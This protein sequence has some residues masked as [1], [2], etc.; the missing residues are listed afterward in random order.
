MVQRYIVLRSFCFIPDH[1]KP[2]LAIF[3][4]PVH[5]SGADCVMTLRLTR[6]LRFQVTLMP[7]DLIQSIDLLWPNKDN[8]LNT[9]I[10]LAQIYELV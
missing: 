10:V 9:E 1:A 4:G 2:N 5:L 3:D 6:D 8:D 7:S